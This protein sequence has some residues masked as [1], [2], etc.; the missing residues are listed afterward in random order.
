MPENHGDGASPE[1]GPGLRSGTARTLRAIRDR[2]L[3][4]TDPRPVEPRPVEPRPGT[5]R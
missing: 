5:T 4:M 1:W 3:G 2:V